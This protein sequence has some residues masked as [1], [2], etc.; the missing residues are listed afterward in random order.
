MIYLSHNARKYKIV[1]L[2]EEL[3]ENLDNWDIENKFVR[4]LKQ[5]AS[6][7]VEESIDDYVWALTHTYVGYIGGSARFSRTDF[8]ANG[9]AA[10]IPEM[11]QAFNDR[12]ATAFISA[13]KDS[14]RLK[15]KIKSP[16]KLKRLRS[17]A[18]I[19]D[20]KVS[21]SF[22]YHDILSKLVDESREESS[23]IPS[24]KA[25][26]HMHSDIKKRRSFFAMLFDAGDVER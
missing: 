9:A 22:E 16:S 8:Y 17:L 24:I 3:K 14:K 26:N 5:F 20:E 23:L 4:E 10:H 15:Q 7:I 11:F 6:V 2:V 21:E 19:I 13:I 18:V 1:P 25:N 12:M